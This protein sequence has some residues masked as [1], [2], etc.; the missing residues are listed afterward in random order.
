MRF[1]YFSLLPEKKTEW[2]DTLHKKKELNSF[3]ALSADTKWALLPSWY[4]DE[5]ISSETSLCLEQREIKQVMGLRI[6]IPYV[7]ILQTVPATHEF[8]SKAQSVFG[9]HIAGT[10]EQ[11]EHNKSNKFKW[12]S[13]RRAVKW[14]QITMWYSPAVGYSNIQSI[15]F[16]S[17]NIQNS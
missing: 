2:D 4:R 16:Q 7:L 5:R 1:Y 11:H 17:Q 8:L 15:I 9:R 10:S 13:S 6:P 14:L 3:S 12:R